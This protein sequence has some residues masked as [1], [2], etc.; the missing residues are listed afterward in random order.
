MR[1]LLSTL[2]L[3]VFCLARPA[4][5]ADVPAD[6]DIDVNGLVV[7]KNEFICLA[8]ND[9]WESRGEPLEGRI[10]V[11]QV[12]LN[13]A[14]D[15]QYPRNLCDVV[16]QNHRRSVYGCQF[17]WNC[18]GRPD[19]PTEA[20]AWRES[21]MLAATVLSRSSAIVDPTD[22][23]LWYHS[24]KVKPAW[25]HGLRKTRTISG[26]VFYREPGRKSRRNDPPYTFA[27]WVNDR[28]QQVAQY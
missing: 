19:H 22:G 17:S 5:A 9:Y 14:M 21:L 10:A 3:A 24:V 20:Q 2:A 18:D 25:S 8:L 15:R 1:A 23:A 28:F 16:K 4:L 27:D 7:S 11:A 26:H 12:V 6:L 13:R